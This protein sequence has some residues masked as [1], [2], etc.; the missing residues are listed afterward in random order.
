MASIIIHVISA[1][2]LAAAAWVA[3][4]ALRMKRD[5]DRKQKQL[6]WIHGEASRALEQLSSKDSSKVLTGLQTLGALNVRDVRL[7]ALQKIAVLAHSENPTV[8]KRAGEALEQMLPTVSERPT[9]GRPSR[10][11]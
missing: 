6:T 3:V 4:S 5:I 8:A 7:E 11:R 10:A 1:L 2:V 9:G